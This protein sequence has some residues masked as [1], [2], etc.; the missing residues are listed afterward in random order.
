VVSPVVA[1]AQEFAAAG[2][3]VSWSVPPAVDAKS[4]G[5]V[6]LI[7]HGTVKEGW[8]VYGLKQLQSGPTPLLVALERNGYATAGG[9]PGGSPPT[10]AQDP[11]FGFVTPYYTH[12]FTLTVP[13]RIRPHLKAGVQSIPV[14]VRFQTCNGQICQ[15]PK[16]I[17]LL[18]PVNISA[19]V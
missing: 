9:K 18:A 13:V 8:H 4:G 7:L 16:T 17:K 2:P 5:H 10:L 6:A 12:D 14:S 15:P 11:A 3:T 19:G 1:L